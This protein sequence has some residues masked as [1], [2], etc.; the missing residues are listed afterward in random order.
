MKN[1]NNELRELRNVKRLK[2]F[3]VMALSNMTQ[4]FTSYELYK[5]I[6]RLMAKEGLKAPSVSWHYQVS[7]HLKNSKLAAPVGHGAK[8]WTKLEQAETPQ[9]ALE[10]KD[11]EPDI[12]DVVRTAVKAGLKFRVTIE[13]HP[14]T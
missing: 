5:E 8:T 6:R 4:D 13:S 14:R 10:L 9:T 12:I 2:A 11:P 7:N 3:G 1:R